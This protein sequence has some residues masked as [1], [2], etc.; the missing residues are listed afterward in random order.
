MHLYEHTCHCKLNTCH[1]YLRIAQKNIFKAWEKAA[2]VYILE[3]VNLVSSKYFLLFTSHKHQLLLG[4]GN[5]RASQKP[6]NSQEHGWQN[7][8]FETR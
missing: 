3:E 8:S 2:I 5:R 4:D 7:P 6:V 1:K